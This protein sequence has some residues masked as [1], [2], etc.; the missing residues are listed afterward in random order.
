MKNNYLYCYKK[1][2]PVAGRGGERQCS[3]TTVKESGSLSQL[4]LRSARDWECSFQAG[5]LHS[6]WQLVCLFST[7]PEQLWESSHLQSHHSD[8]NDTEVRFCFARLTLT[9]SPN[10]LLRHSQGPFLFLPFPRDTHKHTSEAVSL[11]R[12]APSGHSGVLRFWCGSW[13]LE[14]PVLWENPQS[15]NCCHRNP[16]DKKN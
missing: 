16:S 12:D 6:R 15:I 13:A 7:V 2:I 1:N 14:L 9:L 8:R 4:L 3:A 10:T 5:L 11:R